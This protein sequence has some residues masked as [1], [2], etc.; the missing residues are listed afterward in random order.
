MTSPSSRSRLIARLRN[1]FLTGVVVIAPISI[2]IYLTWSFIEWVDQKIM[3]LIPAEYDPSTYLPFSVPG[4]GVVVIV[5]GLTLVG[6][7]TAN[8]LGRTLI[9]YG[10]RL[11]D[12]MPIVRGVY[13]VLKQ[14]IETVLKD[15]GD[16][17]QRVALFEYPRR[18]VWVAG[19]V[20]GDTKGEVRRRVGEDLTSVF[21][22]TTPNPTSGFLLFVPTKDVHF[23]DMSVEEGM[24]FIV[25]VGVVTP[26]DRKA[27]VEVVTLDGLD[28][29]SGGVPEQAKT[30]DKTGDERKSA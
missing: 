2:T 3:P 25:S 27:P 23:L 21:I 24:K 19:F 7:L 10:E 17:F 20:A 26:P 12:R 29:A 15:S 14:I 13:T 22:P 16:S 9:R 4:I 5:L 1:Y 30:D 8:L 11:V 28:H 18:G 6:A